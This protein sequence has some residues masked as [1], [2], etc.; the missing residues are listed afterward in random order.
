MA[1]VRG[2]LAGFPLVLSSATPSIE[3]RVNADAG[4][5]RR[6]VLSDRYAEAKL[7]EIDGDRHAGEP[8]GARA[9]PVAA[10][11]RGGGRDAGREAAG[12]A[13][14][15]P[16][17]LCAA[18]ALPDL[19]PSLPVPELLDLAGRAPVSRRAALPPLRPFGAAARPLPA[20]RRHRKPGRGRAGGRAAGRGGGGAVS[21]GA[22]HRHVERH[23]RR[24]PAAAA[25]PA[26]DRRGRGRHRH[27]HP[28]R[29]Q[30]AQLSA[31]DAGRGGRRRPRAR[32]RRHAG[33]G[34]DLPASQP[35]DRPGRALRRRQPGAAPDLCAGASG[36]PRHRLRR[37]R[38]LLRQRDRGAARGRA[39]ALRPAGRHRHLRH[40]PGRDAGLCGRPSGGPS[41]GPNRSR[42]W[43]RRR[44]RWR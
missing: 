30:G 19:R 36:D 24:H 37:A 3:S 20:M 22:D 29:R 18:D 34:A 25:R 16:A 40:R 39:A 11:G 1:V 10:A 32:L 2:H 31:A 5:Y 26:G 44:R 28:T 35:G 27:R 4:R 21:R 41:R 6:I 9:V 15:Q 42:C 43:G 38:G 13:L 7:P 17:G 33:G 8:A 14:P 23:R 12:A